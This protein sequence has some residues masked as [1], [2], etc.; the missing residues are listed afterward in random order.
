[1]TDL[2]NNIIEEYVYDKLN[3]HEISHPNL[4][5]IWKQYLQNM[6]IKYLQSLV[7]CDN[8]MRN[9]DTTR[10]VSLHS[11]ILLYALINNNLNI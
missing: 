5:N 2:S 9:L 11:I 8:M 6:K 4:T 3:D 10:D 7:D 1:M